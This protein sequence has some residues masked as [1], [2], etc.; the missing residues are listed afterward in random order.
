MAP[1]TR[2][3]FRVVTLGASGC[4]TVDHF[5]VTGDDCGGIALSNN[6]LFY[7]GDT[8]TGRFP[9]ATLA[10][11]VSLGLRLDGL[12]SNLHTGE[13][14]T[15]AVGMTP[16]TR[17]GGSQVISNLLELDGS[18]GALTGRQV[19]LSAPITLSVVSNGS[20]IG[21]FSGYDRAVL[22][23]GTRVINIDLPT[24]VV[25]DLGAM[26]IPMHSACETW[27]FW[28][29]AEFFGGAIYLDYVLNATTINRVRV[30]DGL[31]SPLATFANLSDMC[32]FTVSPTLNRWYFHHEYGSQFGGTEET[33]GYCS[34]SFSINGG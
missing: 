1:T 27:A 15:L 34:A 4:A 29:V 7:S 32:T 25:T 23:T 19:P 20:T 9:I 18:T 16:L 28:G 11:G 8:T 30:P 21:I 6:N 31:I 22:L 10:G 14:F 12:L 3:T 26:A 5:A 2:A 17:G 13:V 24:G 33:A